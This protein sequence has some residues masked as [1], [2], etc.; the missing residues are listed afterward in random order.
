VRLTL[1]PCTYRCFHRLFATARRFFTSS[2]DHATIRRLD[3][4]FAFALLLP[5]EKGTH[6]NAV[7]RRGVNMHNTWR[8][9]YC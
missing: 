5:S 4:D 8:G 1:S 9:L 2:F 3:V 6:H 7:G